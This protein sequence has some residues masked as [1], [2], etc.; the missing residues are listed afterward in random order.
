MFDQF[1]EWEMERCGKLTASEIHKLLV[2]GKAEY[3]GVSAKSYIRMK[4]AELL[5]LIPNN[6]GRVN[7]AALEWGN[8]HEYEAVKRFE[9][10]T[11]KQVE[12]YGGGNP[13][14]FA[15]TEFSGGSPDGITDD[16]IIEVKCPMN[17]GEHIEHLLLNDAEDLKGYY[18]ECYWQ[19]IF[20]M[21]CTGT[22]A[23]Y[24][25]SYDDRFINEALQVKIL[26]IELNPDDEM[27][28]KEAIAEAEKQLSVYVELVKEACLI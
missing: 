20:N 28:L 13:K 25:I 8:A 9:K 26:R 5:T 24:F 22:S 6:G 14:F 10:E 16:G 11:G 7:I 27:R 19:M 4:V 2:K 18:P 1:H 23:G 15:Y 3:F 17:S 21:I 12:Y